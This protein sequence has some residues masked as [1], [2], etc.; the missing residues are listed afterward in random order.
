MKKTALL[1]IFILFTAVGFAQTSYGNEWIK[2]NQTYAKV[3]I[4]EKGIYKITY[5]QL[6]T[7]GFF[8]NGTSTKGFQLFYLGKEIPLMIEGDGDNS[9]E[10]NDYVTFYANPNNGLIDK[11][12]YKTG[13]QP[14]PEVSLFDDEATYFLTNSSTQQ[15]KRYQNT[16]LSSAGITPETHIL[17]AAS[18]NFANQYYPGQYVLDV[19]TFSD[20]IEGEGYLGN[21]FGLGS[22]QNQLLNTPNFFVGSTFK[23]LFESYVA[24]RSNASSTNSQG[25]N[26]HLNITV[27]GIVAKDTVYR[28][29]KTVRVSELLTNAS[30]STATNVV[31][32]SINDLGATTDFQAPGYARI[33]Y[34]RSL[35]ASDFNFLE[36]KLNSLNNNCLVNFNKTSLW[37]NPTLLNP[38][39]AERHQGVKT[40]AVS[41]FVL[42]NTASPLVVYNDSA[43]KSTTLEPVQFNPINASS[44]NAKML[45]VTDKSLLS[46]VNNIVSY[47]NSRG[48]SCLAISTEELYNQFSYGI[49]SAL[50][51]RNYCKFLLENST[52]KPEFLF[53]IGKGYELS[54]NHLTD[55]MVP[56]FGYPPSDIGITSHLLDNNLA[57][58]LATGRISAKTLDDVKNYLDKIKSYDNQPN[59]LWRKN[60]INITGGANNN[61]D[62]QFSSY[63]KTLGNTAQKEFF[64]AK[65]T[66][67]YKNVSDPITDNF[68]AKINETVEMGTSMLTYLGHGSAINTAIS[69]GN[70]ENLKNK[71]KLPFYYINGCSTGNAFVQ[72]CLGENYVGQ[73]EVGAIGWIGTSS[74]GVASYLF[75]VG[76]LFFQNSFN[77]NYGKS[78]AQN[79][80]SAIR[81]YQNPNDAL[82]KI[83]CQQYIYLGDPSLAFYSPTKPDYDITNQDIDLSDRNVNASSKSFGLKIIVRNIGKA[84]TNNVSVKVSRTLS[85]NSVITYSPQFFNKILNTDTLTYEINNDILNTAGNNKF[86]VYIDDNNQIDEQ[87]EQNNIAHFEYFIPSNG[88]TIISPQ[89]YT[90]V[91]N[92]DFTLKV[93]SNDLFAKNLGYFFEIDTLN[94]FDTGWKKQSLLINSGLFAEWKPEIS[95]EN[96]KVYYWRARLNLAINDGGSWKNG[97]FVNIQNGGEGWSQAHYQQYNDITLHN[98][99]NNSKNGFEFTKT[100]YPIIIKTRGNNAP[101]TDERRIRLSI[102]GGT[103]SFN[104]S[105]FP[106]FSLIALNPINLSY[107]N[108]PSAFNYKNDGINGSGQ[109]FF[110]T[111]NSL[112]VDSLV[113]YINKIPTG[114]FVV[115]IS[116]VNFAAKD[117]PLN[118]KQALATLGLFKYNSIA[119]G[120]PYAFITKKND[121]NYNALEYTADYSSVTPANEQKIYITSDILTPWKNGYYFSEKIGP[122]LSWSNVI[123]DFDANPNTSFIYSV[124]GVNDNGGEVKLKSGIKA[125]ISINDVDANVY[126]YLR[127][128]T[129]VTNDVDFKPSNLKAWQVIYQ[130]YPE[131]TLNPE[132]ANIFYKP[133]IEEGDSVKLSLGISNISK[134]LSDS[135]K[136]S[137]SITKADRSI[138]SASIQILAP[139]PI[140]SNIKTSFSYGT[141]NLVGNNILKVVISPK[142]NKDQF[143]FNNI[144]SYNFNVNKDQKKPLL[145]V[146][147]D[148]KRIINGEIVSPDP[149]IS[150]SI[151]D[152]N[153]YLFLNDTTTIE[154]YLKSQSD[155]NF[156]RI[157]F[158]SFKI[159]IKNVSNNSNKITYEVLPGMLPDGIFTIKLV[160]KD[161][162]G[163]KLNDDYLSDFE[164]INEQT[165]TDVLPYPNP[166]TNSTRF[167]FKLTGAKIPDD[168]KIQI[169]TINGKIVKE[170][171]K[172]ELGNLR[173]GNNISDYSWDG[174]DT[175]GDRL[176]NGIYFYQVIIRNN[177]GT[178]Y[179]K[180]ATSISKN[181]KNNFGK[182]YLMK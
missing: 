89:N 8:N 114:Y 47:K 173:I 2:S 24:G 46:G 3:K 155:G 153:K 19:M 96:N 127:I 160:A 67:F 146:L 174:T 143:D 94:S 175:F 91:D 17:Y 45:I 10:S 111:N 71:N 106:G 131:I 122:A 49:H 166:V 103:P 124:F 107:Y 128:K 43:I 117:L 87:N 61:E 62:V 125:T 76:N 172:E 110:N 50:A 37:G 157:S 151:I 150:V 120:E 14:N 180:K 64:G 93:Q 171:L 177:D 162:S 27:D 99:Q 54:K 164:V 123:F 28:G 29:Y 141:K 113:A 53:L 15:G 22:S 82:N 147:F 135:L 79:L 60:I 170:I 70:P 156:K 119:N 57:P 35:D 86:T 72:A 41:A 77:N 121:P 78:I 159:N 36:F 142:N 88:L 158:S 75:G 4:T 5:T 42:K 176:A 33:T 58:A 81:A 97:S 108:Y 118:A 167:V 40:A 56:T 178:D 80:A 149:H 148:G 26:H 66:S 7:L 98:I 20:Y 179:K 74:E 182:L 90:I 145:D 68:T 133:Q 134:I 11:D 130:Q 84:I 136:V 132:F 161:K 112:E 83:H 152:E 48:V 169:M 52:I 105:E 102:S 129:E 34:P 55:E 9:F 116:G 69:I 165:I 31:F 1:I 137:F 73:K 85:D 6:Q 23:P 12:L 95:L 101:A 168:M 16:T 65:I 32:G 59:E 163:N 144:L 13:E 104:T 25:N 139:L 21:T 44:L 30:L 115:A 63:L 38:N 181:F 138:V 109:F 140:N 126:K 18:K 51:I 154:V 92:A 100:A 39:T